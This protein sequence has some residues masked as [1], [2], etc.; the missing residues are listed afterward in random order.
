MIINSLLEEDGVFPKENILNWL[1]G[2]LREAGG[3]GR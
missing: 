2:Y 3:I 1:I